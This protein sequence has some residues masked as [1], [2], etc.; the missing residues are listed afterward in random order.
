MIFYGI[1]KLPILKKDTNHL[2]ELSFFESCFSREVFM[3][4]SETVCSSPKRGTA[5]HVV[6]MVENAY[7]TAKT[8]ENSILLLD[9]Y[10]LSVPALLF[11]LWAYYSLSP[12][13][14]FSRRLPYRS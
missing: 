6:Q 11:R 13:L 12:K 2:K 7:L 3:F 5:F 10:F 14:N 9:R 4:S 1:F 8:F